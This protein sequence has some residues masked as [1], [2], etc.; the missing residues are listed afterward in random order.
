MSDAANSRIALDFLRGIGSGA[1]SS[2]GSSSRNED[3]KH[4]A[5]SKCG[6]ENCVCADS[7]L[8]ACSGLQ[9]KVVFRSKVF[10]ALRSE[11]SHTCFN[12]G[13]ATWTEQ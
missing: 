10:C 8:F 7:F 11:H 1:G 12:A 3:T 4:D 9:E 2:S 6:V 5:D 13:Q